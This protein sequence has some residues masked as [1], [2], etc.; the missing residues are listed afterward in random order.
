MV[1]ARADGDPAAASS[2][3]APEVESSHTARARALDDRLNHSG[4]DD[5]IALEV[6]PYEKAPAQIAQDSDTGPRI[7]TASYPPMAKPANPIPETRTQALSPI[8]Q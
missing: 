1:W 8:S 4:L 2:G 5:R 7:L 3:P 6:L